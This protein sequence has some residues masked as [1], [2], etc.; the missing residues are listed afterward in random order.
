MIR[1][2]LLLLSAFFCLGIVI[3]RQL[4]VSLEAW[5]VLSGIFLVATLIYYIIKRYDTKKA[6][7]CFLLSSLFMGSFWYALNHYPAHLHQ[8]LSGQTVAGEGTIINYP[9]EG[10]YDYSFIIKVTELKSGDKKIQSMKKLILKVKHSKSMQLLPGTK[11]SF[12]GEAEIPLGAR[13]P[14]GFDYRNYLANKGI[15][16]QIKCSEQSLKILN[17]GGGLRGQ[18]AQAREKIRDKIEEILPERESGLLLGFLFGDT[19]GIP[20]E[21]WD[22]Y[23]RAGVLHLFAVSGLHVAFMLGTA[24]FLLS[25]F[26]ERQVIKIICG[27]IVLVMYYFLIGW[28]VSFVRAA[29]MVFLSMLALLTGRKKDIY[30]SIALAIGTI[31][32]INPGELFQMGFQM[33]FAATAGI[34]YLTPFLE[35]WG[36]GKALSTAVA[37]HIATLPLIAY[38][39]NL[40]SLVAPLLN[41]FAVILSSL[42]ASVGL[43]GALFSCILPFLAE[44]FFM[45]AGFLLYI[46][47]EIVIR[48]ASFNCAAL[49]VSSPALSCLIFIYLAILF[50]P[51]LP[52]AYPYLRLLV[53]RYK[54]ITGAAIIAILLI[55]FWPQAA[56]MEV[57]FIDVGQGDSIFIRTPQGI[58]VLVDGGGTPGTDYSIGKN[59]IKPFLLKKGL[60]KVDI[61]MMTHNHLDHSEGL[62]ELLPLMKAGY[63]M[64]PPFEG[65]NDIENMILKLCQKNNIPV[66]E[67]IAGERIWLDKESCLEV[68]HPDINVKDKGNNRSLVLRIVYKNTTWLITGDVENKAIDEILARRENVDADILKLP[69]H[70]SISSYNPKFYESVSPDAVV[71]SVGYNLYNQPHPDVMQY[72][73]EHGI[74]S[75]L[76]KENGAILTESDGKK[77]K[78]RTINN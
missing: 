15:F 75:Y 78:I 7:I 50:L 3:S 70:G 54:L 43:I 5:G 52:R 38:Y 40:I 48:V 16:F 6:G 49:I 39:F 61:M 11:I 30:T 73:K 36:F 62:L 58:T 32:I 37:A 24:Y 2:Y 60:E 31:L 55:N 29:I 17:I 33:S 66:K 27:V 34:V 25:L 65:S 64:S 42:I 8:E 26:T 10:K 72:F 1:K 67:L 57:T 56:M 19:T 74:A 22:I 13:N 35:R 76:T 9:R 47:S 44:P 71:V 46:L 18:I 53:Y 23:Q 69:H 28:Q 14:G 20:E 63:F 4:A 45:A 68:L 21:D 41:V 77:I 51:Q 59:V 12:R